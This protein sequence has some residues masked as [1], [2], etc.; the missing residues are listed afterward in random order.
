MKSK[1]KSIKIGPYS[2]SKITTYD[3]NHYKGRMAGVVYGKG[4]YPIKKQVK[5]ITTFGNKAKVKTIDY[6]PKI[7]DFGKQTK[8]RSIRKVRISGQGLGSFNYK[9]R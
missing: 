5:T 6:G 7:H 3:P 2:R 8:T 9:K 4:K 1:V